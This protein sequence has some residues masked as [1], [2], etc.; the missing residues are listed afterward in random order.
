M[1]KSGNKNMDNK[2]SRIEEV[3]VKL[4]NKDHKAFIPFITAGFP[5]LEKYLDLFFMLDRSGADIIEIGVPFSDPIADGPVL[6]TT[7]SI[8]LEN[9]IDM[10]KIFKSIETIRERSM[11]PVVLLVYFNMILRYGA[12]KFLETAKKTGVDGIIIP[13]LPVEEFH[14]YNR[15]FLKNKIDPIML[16]S[17]TSSKARIRKIISKCRGFLYCISVKGVTGERKNIDPEFLKLLTCLRK[18]TDIPVCP[19]FGI[20]NLDQVKILKTH[21][22]GIIIGS[23]LSSMIL[24]S[25][26]LQKGMARIEVFSKDINKI[27][28]YS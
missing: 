17:L 19:G 21:C 28:K 25:K 2:K 15:I 13:D 1:Q 10:D 12:D 6:Q 3:F 24:E 7:S 9:G 8:A 4:R 23:R 14:I 26:D 27:L 18:L 11:I 16:I 20:S 5:D 22:D